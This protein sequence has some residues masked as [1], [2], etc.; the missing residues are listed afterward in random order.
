MSSKNEQERHPQNEQ[1]YSCSDDGEIY[2]GIYNDAHFEEACR[3][4]DDGQWK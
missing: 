2:Q 1:L 3:K 4:A